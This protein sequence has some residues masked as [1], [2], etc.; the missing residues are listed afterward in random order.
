MEPIAASCLRSFTCLACVWQGEARRQ[1][2]RV[3]RSKRPLRLPDQEDGREGQRAHANGSSGSNYEMDIGTG[4]EVGW[5]EKSL[6]QDNPSRHCTDDA[7]NGSSPRLYHSRSTGAYTDD[8]RL[9][10]VFAQPALL[11]RTHRYSSG[12]V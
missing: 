4:T 2:S 3:P 9:D 1:R 5:R 10:L 6:I 8:V 7:L 12:I 11:P